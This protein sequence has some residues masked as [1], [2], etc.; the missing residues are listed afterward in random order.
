MALFKTLASVVAWLLFIFGLLGLI[1]R[2]IV[3]LTDTGFT[4][5]DTAQLTTDFAVLG[6]YLFASV[7]VMRLRQKME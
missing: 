3:W 7:V 6:L 5:T 1:S 4:G 2:A